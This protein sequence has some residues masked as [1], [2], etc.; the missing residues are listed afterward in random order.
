MTSEISHV[1]IISSRGSASAGLRRGGAGLASLA[2]PSL[3][4]FGSPDEQ[5]NRSG[6]KLIASSGNYK[7]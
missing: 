7:Q 6:G 3:A 4:P 1:E 5:A 2:F